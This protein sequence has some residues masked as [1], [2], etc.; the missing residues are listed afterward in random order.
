VLYN[1]EIE[2]LEGDKRLW[3]GWGLSKTVLAFCSKY[4][5]FV[6]IVW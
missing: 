2:I 5:S 1:P 4:W 3:E 6:K